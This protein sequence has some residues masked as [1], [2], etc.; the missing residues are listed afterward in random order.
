M[1]VRFSKAI[2]LYKSSS[3]MTCTIWRRSSEERKRSEV[4]ADV[5]AN[6]CTGR[7]LVT[8]NIYSVSS[9]LA[10]YYESCCSFLMKFTMQHGG[11]GKRVLA[12]RQLSVGGVTGYY[13]GSLAYFYLQ[14]LQY[15]KN[16]YREVM[17]MVAVEQFLK[18]SFSM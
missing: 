10:V 7:R 14:G 12:V 18:C 1:C 8:L 13:S 4:E 15:L 2:L 16:T 6:Q 17:S 3:D 5:P 9:L 11:A